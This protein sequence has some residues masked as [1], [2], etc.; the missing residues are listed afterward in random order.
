MLAIITFVSDSAAAGAL[1]AEIHHTFQLVGPSLTP[2][3]HTHL[4]P[5]LL[6]Q[7]FESYVATH[8]PSPSCPVP[9]QAEESF[10]FFDAS[11]D[12]Y[13][14]RVRLHC[15]PEKLQLSAGCTLPECVP[16]L[17]FHHALLSAAASA[18]CLS[19]LT[20]SP[21]PPRAGCRMD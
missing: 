20:P 17:A 8:A 5:R 10:L 16:C 2:R 19:R 1:D 14:Q 13:I 7:H 21:D 6:K 18:S 9:P 11:H 3:C 12:G 4:S 15:R